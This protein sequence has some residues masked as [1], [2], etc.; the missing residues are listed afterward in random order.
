MRKLL[1]AAGAAMAMAAVTAAPAW[2]GDLPL[3]RNSYYQPQPAAALFNWTG[4]YLGANAGYGWGSAIGGDPSGAVGGFT[5]GY[6]Y[7]FSPNMVIGAETDITFSTADTSRPA[8]KFESDYIGTLRAR[9]G[10]SVGNVMFYG[11]AGAA[12]GKGELSVGGLTNDQT[13]WG[14][15]IGAGIEAM[16]TQNVSAKFE[17][18]YVDLSDRNYATIGGPVNVGYTTNLLRGGVNYRF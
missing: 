6:N 11:T 2:A 4:F 17:Y 12:Y 18:L 5:A 14:W 1:L 13:H 9:V 7:Q 15:T 8:G 3:Q 16:L 10:Y